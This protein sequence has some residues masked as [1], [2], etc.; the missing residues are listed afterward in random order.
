MLGPDASHDALELLLV[1]VVVEARGVELGAQAD[2][3]V[4]SA[5]QVL[6]AEAAQLAGPLG[7]DATLLEREVGED[8]VDG[9]GLADE[10]LGEV[11]EAG[12]SSRLLVGSGEGVEWVLVREEL[13][14]VA[15]P[16]RL[17]VLVQLE[18]RPLHDLGHALVGVR[19]W[20]GV[21]RCRLDEVVGG[22]E[23]SSC[24]KPSLKRSS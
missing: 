3:L 23:R 7:G 6:H 11:E 16:G 8:R 20:T 4:D 15:E 17:Q 21:P 10:V 14:R 22:P 12:P 2:L 13:T 24:S 19:V 9:A 18:A 1:L 5:G